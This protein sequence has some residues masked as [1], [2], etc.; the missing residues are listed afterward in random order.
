[1]VQPAMRVLVRAFQWVIAIAVIALA[2]WLS[3]R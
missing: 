1:M 2:A 3:L